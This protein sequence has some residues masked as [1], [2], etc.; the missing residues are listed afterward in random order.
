[1]TAAE[2]AWIGL[3]AGLCVAAV[4]ATLSG[5][6]P[7]AIDWQPARAA[8]EPW[9]AFS[10]A[11]V[12]Y[13]MLHLAANLAGAALVAALGAAAG[14]TPAAVAAWACAW[15]LTQLGLL[16]RP[17]LSHYGGLSGV[18]HAGAAVVAVHLLWHGV[19]ARRAIGAAL[20]AGLVCKVLIEAPWGAPLRIGT[21]WDFATAPLA[22]ATGLVA[23]TLCAAAAT[24]FR[25]RA[26]P[27]RT[28]V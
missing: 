1:M 11:A 15:P 5:I 9:R 19:G 21:G 8:N 17:D 13:S 25:D 24:L 10:A 12:H 16:V 3:A 27:P 7:D 28:D 18:L 26:P 2:R 20:A 4:A 6:A 23:G 14:V 22:H